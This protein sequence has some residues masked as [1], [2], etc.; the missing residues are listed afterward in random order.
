MNEITGELKKFSKIC[1]LRCSSKDQSPLLQEKDILSAFHLEGHQEFEENNSAW[2]DN[3]KRPEFEKVIELIK[4][5]KVRDFYVWDLDRIYRNLNRLKEFFL[6]CKNYNCKIHSY[7]QRWLDELNSIMP[8]FDVIVLELM[9]NIL[10]WLGETEST[11]KSARVKMAIVK[12]DKGTYS[13]K[14]NKWGRKAFP[15]QTIERVMELH[16]QKKSIREIANSVFV[17]D[18]NNNSKKISKSAVHKIIVEKA[19]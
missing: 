12:K 7:N 6:L 10:G 4:K 15:K 11:K 3:V 5:G 14:G 19:Q 16:L 8:P 1:Y 2:K 9:I 18:K 13:Y 17:Y